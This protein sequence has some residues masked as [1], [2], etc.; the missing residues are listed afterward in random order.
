MRMIA[1]DEPI[2]L[3]AGEGLVV[4]A[5]DVI[6]VGRGDEV[7][8]R[9]GAQVVGPA[10]LQVLAVGAGQGQHGPHGG[11]EAQGLAID[12][13]ALALF[14][15]EAIE[16]VA[17]VVGVAVDRAVHRH[18]LGLVRRVVGLLLQHLGQVAADAEEPGPADAVLADDAQ[19][20]GARR[21][22]GGDR[23]LELIGLDPA[24]LEARMIEMQ[25]L[26]LVEVAASDV[27][28]HL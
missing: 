12:D 15:R 23:D 3:A 22:I 24:C 19:L 28:G 9:I 27:D 14:G 5:H 16:I 7:E 11:I 8:Q 1:D 2:R 20:I 25:L 10:L 6:A 21:R 18:D 26:R 4:N 17:V 13:D